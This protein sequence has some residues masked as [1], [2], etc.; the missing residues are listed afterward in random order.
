MQGLSADNWKLQL[1]I[2]RR[3]GV[4]GVKLQKAAT[5]TQRGEVRVLYLTNRKS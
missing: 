5:S 4:W 3:F 1:K 2:Y